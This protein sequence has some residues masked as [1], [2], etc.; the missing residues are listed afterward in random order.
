[1]NSSTAEQFDVAIVGAGFAGIYAVWRLRRD[2]LKVVVFEAGDDVGGTWYW[3]RYPGA[4]CD[5]E[6]L[7][8][9]Y[10]FDPQLE[11][12]WKWSQRFAR[13]PEIL[14][15]MQHVVERHDLRRHMRF[16]RRV[17]SAHWDDATAEWELR[18]D[19][20]DHVRA[21][22]VIMATGS[23]STPKPLDYPGAAAFKGRTLF[24][25]LWPREKVDFTGQR[26]GVIG[27]GSSAIQSIPI[28]AA[29][30]EQLT[31]FQRTPNFSVPSGNTPMR[32]DYEQRIKSDYR[33]LRAV[34]EASDV[35]IVAGM[36]PLTRASTDD[37]PAERRAEFERRWAQGGLYFYCSYTDLMVNEAANAEFGE[38]AREK[39]RAK[40]RDPK[41]AAKLVPTGY[42]FGAK[43]MCAD[44]GYFETYNRDNVSLV[45]L[46]E[47][48]IDH[49]SERGVVT[50][51]GTE[52]ALDMLIVATGF[53]AMT[54]TLTR[55]D[56]RGR[57]G[58][59]FSDH[60]AEG[61]KHY[62]GIMA[63]G[64]PNLYITTGPGTPS[65]LYNMVLGNQF[66]VDWIADAIGTL[67][68]HGQQRI[69]AEPAAEAEWTQH[70]QDV[71]NMTLFTKAN[72]WYVG[73]NVPGKPRVVLPYLGGFQA[74]SARCR[75][76]AA[77]GYTGFRRA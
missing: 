23:L 10:S 77:N 61:P 24:T 5:I 41:I 13:Q 60:W 69:E 47:T 68:A 34:E 57:D 19:A 72:S 36:L 46:R 50:A 39:I 64:F 71:G 43:R 49:L 53:D 42:P 51:D 38:F 8:Y 16:S 3:N 70:V 67:R 7:E 65:V 44:D 37:T 52:H 40:I 31:V 63:S 75:E 29:E 1:M 54:G 9:S 30:C 15:Y 35:G 22:H 76:V 55:I 59:R 27:T 25:S 66:H 33:G 74:Y 58:R 14:A 56:I 20:G 4:A 12:D 48:P 6:S 2:G 45:D 32:P 17:Q 62:L 26:V 28:I 18:S 73:A 21:P 11:Q